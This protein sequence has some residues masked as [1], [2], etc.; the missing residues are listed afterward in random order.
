MTTMMLVAS[1]PDQRPLCD[2]ADRGAVATKK[3]QNQA[4]FLFGFR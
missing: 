4:C 1:T 2:P 3:N